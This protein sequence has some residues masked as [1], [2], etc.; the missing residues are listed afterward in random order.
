MLR[1]FVLPACNRSTFVF[2]CVSYDISVET[3]LEKLLKKKKK[4]LRLNAARNGSLV[5]LTLSRCFLMFPAKVLAR[6]V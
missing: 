5:Q 3:L 4:K 2:V 1:S 6:S